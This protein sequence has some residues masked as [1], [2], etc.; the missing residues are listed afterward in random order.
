MTLVY[1]VAAWLAGIAL[2]KPLSIPWWLW[3][4]LAG[5]AGLAFALARHRP[6]WRILLACAVLL[7]L[8]AARL[9]LALPR[10]DES[11]LATYNGLGFATIEGVVIDSPDVRDAHANLRVRAELI[12]LDG[13]PPRPVKGIALVQVA[14][15]GSYRYGDPVRVRGELVSPP[16]LG[17]FSYR[18]YLARQGVFSLVRY[19]QVEVIGERRGS[20]IRAAMLDFRERAN[21]VIIRLLPDP[22]GA[23]LSGILLG[24]E[25]RISPGVREAFNAVSAT[26]VIVISGSNLVILAGV[27]QSVARRVFRKPGW[28]AALTIAGVLAYAVFVGGDAAV[29]RA[30]IMTTLALIATQLGRQTYGLASLAFAALLMTAI[31]PT[32]LWDVS[33]Q[34]SCLATL[35]LVL[36][37][38]PMQ[39]LLE[40]GLAWVASQQ[41]ARTTVGAVSDAL[42]V[43]V[44]AQ[45]TTTPIMAYTFRRF[46][47]LS[48]PVN[49]LI[50]PVQT[51]LM[52]LGGLAVIAALVAWPV[53]QALAWGSW[54]FLT[55]T[56]EV[57]RFF[58]GLPYASLEVTAL[59]PWAVAGIYGLML[60]ATLFATQPPDQRT[61]QFEWLRQALGVKA[62]AFTGLLAAALLF[63]AAAS[64]PDGRV[65]VTFIDVGDGAATLIETPGGRQVLVDAG[66]SGRQLSTA[67]GR[68]LPFWDQRID[69][70][71]LTQ[72]GS[73]QTAGLPAILGRYRF[74]AVLTSSPP[75]ESETMQPVWDTLHAQGVQ[76][77]VAS[78]GMRVAVG[79]GVTLTVLQGQPAPPGLEGEASEP[80]ILMLAYEDVRVL[81]AGSLT[82]EGEATL[83]NSGSDLHA[84]VLQVPHAGHRDTSSEGFLA[85]VNPQV[86]VISVGE[87]NRFGLPHKEALER[88]E[89]SG[90]ALYRTDR[91]GAVR[92]LSDGVRLWIR[93][94]R[95][96]RP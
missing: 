66:G 41:T 42:I 50:V 76:P 37:V 64:Q 33:F 11:S 69:L 1:L 14:R 9:Q 58:A 19:A 25:S 62:L 27:I 68:A 22:Q 51:P 67:L 40:S 73:A 61:R 39:K 8:G 78:P 13:S 21:Q 5:L 23:L 26:H 90:A 53:G 80:L 20:P 91:D 43:T 96:A 94:D 88:L 28:A 46:S 52:V 34:L 87:G 54:L 95:P 63:A 29:I 36:Y 7:A 55:W 83:V 56:A 35:G 59:S 81:L 85:A 44:A 18:D 2:A 49:F 60:G 16:E 82:P 15:L 92:V 24:I 77:V 38:E 75:G 17:E 3:L 32:T 70:L 89:A 71:V 12:A 31:N 6:T 79:D 47:L 10:H 57:V 48:L 4:T 74:D 84:A 30:A 65:R 86:A 93:A 45:I 72:P